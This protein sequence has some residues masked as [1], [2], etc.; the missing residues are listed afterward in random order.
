MLRFDKPKLEGPAAAIIGG[1]VGS[2]LG[3]GSIVATMAG[4][5]IGGALLG[6]MGQ[7]QP[8]YPTAQLPGAPTPPQLPQATEL[9]TTGAATTPTNADVTKGEMATNARR[10][11]LSTILSAS[12]KAGDQ[13]EKLGG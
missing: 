5:L 1:A 8:S 9:P 7:K 4:S 11:R 12:N 3:G 13:T 2:W 10:G 6:G